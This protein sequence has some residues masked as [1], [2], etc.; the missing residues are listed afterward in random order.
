MVISKYLV[1]LTNPNY[2]KDRKR[3]SPIAGTFKRTG[4][5]EKTRSCQ[6]NYPKTKENSEHVMLVDLM[7]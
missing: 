7:T 6:N 2:R 5:D 4:D 1:L 3:N